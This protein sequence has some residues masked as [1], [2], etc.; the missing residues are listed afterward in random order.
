M[1]TRPSSLPCRQAGI[2]H[3]P[4]LKI[5]TL[6][7]CY[8]LLATLLLGCQQPQLYKRSQLLIGTTIEVTSIDSRAPEIVFARIKEIEK[9]FS[10]FD[11]DSQIY[12]LNKLGALQVSKEVIDLIKKAKFFNQIS[13]G[14]FDISVGPLVDIWKQAIKTQKLPAQ[15]QIDKARKLAGMDK[16]TIEEKNSTIRFKRKGMNIDLGAIA[17]GYA[18]DV[19]IEALKKAGIKDAL[20]SAGGDMYCLGTKVGEPWNIGIQHP[21][22]PYE[23]IGY[24]KLANKAVAT[25]GDYEQFFILDNKRYSHIID[26]KTGYPA[27][28][29]VIS[30]TVM[31]PDCLTADALATSIMVLGKEKGGELAKKFKDVEVRILTNDDVG[32]N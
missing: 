17:K 31:A 24:L 4:S 14:A 13:E 15:S 21:R 7:T 18:V 16:I 10:K 6:A 32:N 29:K 20:V 8:L 25:S 26:P 12:Q 11:P 23:V 5:T 22:K 27:D 30:V 2:V 19:A 3:R 1:K 9:V 28:K